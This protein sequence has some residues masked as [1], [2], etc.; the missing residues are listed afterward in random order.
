MSTT[1]LCIRRLVNKLLCFLFGHYFNPNI[2]QDHPC[3]T[4]MDKFNC[5]WCGVNYFDLT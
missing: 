3:M 2:N 1:A 4:E 5:K